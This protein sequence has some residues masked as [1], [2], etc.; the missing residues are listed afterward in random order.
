MQRKVTGGSESFIVNK[1]WAEYRDGFGSAAGNDNYWL[2]LD[3][4]YRLVQ[5]GSVSLRI[6][7]CKFTKLS[8][9]VLVQLS[10]CVLCVAR[11]TVFEIFN[12]RRRRRGEGGGTSP[13]KKIGKK[14]FSGNYYVQ[15]WHF[16]AKI[17]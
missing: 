2:G 3:K 14:Y 12:H 16:R 8:A 7:V 6:E 9:I 13:P 15:F 11:K 5:L 10:C 17:V 4:V 1:N